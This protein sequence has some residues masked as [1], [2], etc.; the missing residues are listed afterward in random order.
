[1]RILVVEDEKKV[2]SF[3][4]RGLEAAQYAVDV[5]YDG[6]A[7][8][9]RLQQGG[10]DAVVL[11]RSIAQLHHGRIRLSSTPRQGSR[12]RVEL[13]L[14]EPSARIRKSLDS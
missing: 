1:M 14:A 9:K 5:E 2:A 3:V 12:F 8:L 13:P 4:K 7:G 11:V 10:Y 6:V